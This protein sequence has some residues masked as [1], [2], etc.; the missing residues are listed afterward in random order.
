MGKTGN[1]GVTTVTSD[2][3]GP[4]LRTLCNLL[5][6][7]RGLMPSPPAAVSLTKKRKDLLVIIKPRLV[8]LLYRKHHRLNHGSNSSL[9]GQA[10][11]CVAVHLAPQ[12]AF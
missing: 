7:L 10:S 8:H 5:W 1:I 2:A 3:S 12:N 9:P 4:H 11:G 6:A